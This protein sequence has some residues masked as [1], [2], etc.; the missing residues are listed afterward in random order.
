MAGDKKETAMSATT[1]TIVLQGLLALVP[2]NEPGGANQM[3]V[4]M[5]DGNHSHGIQC[6][7][8]HNPKLIVRADNNACGQAECRPVG[9]LCICEKALTRKEI[10]LEIQP[11]PDPPRQEL[12]KDPP[13][14]IPRNREEAAELGY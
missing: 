5:L 8:E 10:W 14:S 4:L 2:N 13:R 11:Q 1:L 7:G 6:M 12:P 3:K 9:G